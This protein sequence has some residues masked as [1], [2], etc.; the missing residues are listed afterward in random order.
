MCKTV[1]AKK[2]PIKDKEEV[3]NKW[4]VLRWYIYGASFIGMVFI[5]AKFE[6]VEWL[7]PAESG[8]LGYFWVVFWT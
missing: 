8:L 3:T 4:Q 7:I 5:D 1:I 6:F 2:N